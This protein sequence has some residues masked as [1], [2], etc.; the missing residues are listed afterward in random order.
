MMAGRQPFTHPVDPQNSHPPLGQRRS[1][2]CPMFPVYRPAKMTESPDYSGTLC[3]GLLLTIS[4]VFRVFAQKALSGAARRN[5]RV[6]SIG[7]KTQNG[8][9]FSLLCSGLQSPPSVQVPGAL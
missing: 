3:S 5:R 7:A 4:R 8:T 6:A 1:D 2:C 9:M